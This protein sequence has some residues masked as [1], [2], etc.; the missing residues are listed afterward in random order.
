MDVEAELRKDGFTARWRRAW[1]SKNVFELQGQLLMRI[2]VAKRVS[3]C[4]MCH[5]PVVAGQ[6]RVE[7]FLR[8]GFRRYRHGG[9]SGQIYYVHT[10]C[11]QK[12]LEGTETGLVHVPDQCVCCRNVIERVDGRIQGMPFVVTSTYMIYICEGCSNLPMFKMCVQCGLWSYKVRM[13]KFVHSSRYICHHC[14]DELELVGRATSEATVRSV[15]RD[16]LLLK[17]AQKGYAEAETW[18]HEL[19]AVRSQRSQDG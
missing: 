4:R 18:V 13:T 11:M 1:E 14:D 7:F 16:T 17:K 3:K 15:R 2:G 10:S 19:G 6:D 9:S 12:F 5:T 8:F